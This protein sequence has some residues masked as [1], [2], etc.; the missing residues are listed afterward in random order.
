MS[1]NKPN[2]RADAARVLFDILEKGLSSREALPSLQAKHSEQDKAWLQEMVF[3]VLRQLPVLQFWLRQMLDKPLKK[4]AKIA[5]HLIMLGFYQLAFTRV[6]T[7]A[8][9]SETVSAAKPLGVVSLKG[10]VNAVLR[11]FIREEM[12]QKLPDDEQ[13]LSGLPKWLFKKLVQAYPE[14]K[15]SLIV[16]MNNRP[17]IWL[18]V[19]Q[20]KL[21]VQEYEDALK[22][23]S[24]EFTHSEQHSNG[25]ILTKGR[26]IT[27]LPGYQQ[28]WFSVQDGAAQLAAEYLDAQPGERILDC[29]AAPGGKTCHILESQ[30]ELQTC[31]ALD[32]DQ[33][34]MVRIQENLDRLNLNAELVC[35]DASQSEQWWDGKMFDRILLDAPCSAT[36]VIR[37][38]PDIRW[39]RKGTD[40]EVLISLQKSILQTMWGL[41]KPGGTLLYAT[42][43]I[44]PEENKL[45][46]KAF[47][48]SHSDAVLV[49]ICRSETAEN[50]GRQILPGEGQMDGFYYARLLKSS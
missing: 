13:V 11:N 32:V 3:G 2:L 30:P 49:P 33:Q 45:Q 37:K 24:I 40:I 1:G 44:L 18:R 22:R 28:G 50:P 29:C 31:I 46:V 12:E 42:C 48:N 4:K 17:P 20:R 6:S 38:H 39:L 9:V 16:E 47:L 41:L 34:R 26:D 7:H 5:E 43:S 27:T 36:G 35:A 10:L 14:N 23:Q 8:A 21:S 25:L 19:N 15:Q